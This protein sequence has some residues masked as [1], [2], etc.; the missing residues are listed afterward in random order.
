MPTALARRRSICQAFVR[1]AAHDVRGYLDAVK[2]NGISTATLKQHMAAIRMLLD[3]LVPGACEVRVVVFETL[4][5]VAALAMASEPRS[6]ASIN[7]S[8]GSSRRHCTP[9][10]ANT[11]STTPPNSYGIRSRIVLVP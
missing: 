1:A 9:S 6:P 5:F 8:A 2:A 3:H 7:Q 4:Y 10:G 11:R